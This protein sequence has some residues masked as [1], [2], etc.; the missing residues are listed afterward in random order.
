MDKAFR[1][2]IDVTIHDLEQLRDYALQRALIDTQMSA[3]EFETGESEDTESNIAYWLGWAFDAGT[4][5]GCGF[6]IE[7]SGVEDQNT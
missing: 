1:V 6:Q 4:P 2:H 5:E 7:N 3:A